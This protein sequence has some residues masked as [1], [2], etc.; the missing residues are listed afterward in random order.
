MNKDLSYIGYAY[1]NRNLRELVVGVA[2]NGVPIMSGLSEYGLDPFYPKKYV[3][4][5]NVRS[6]PVDDCLGYSALS[7]FYHYYSMSPCILTSTF[8]TT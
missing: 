2:F 8:K 5:F 4:L 6:I 3:N 7:G 1:D